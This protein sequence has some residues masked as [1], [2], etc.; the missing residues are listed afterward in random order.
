MPNCQGE[1]KIKKLNKRVCDLEATVLC[2]Q[3]R[4]ER[5]TGRDFDNP[6]FFFFSTVCLFF[7]HNSEDPKIF[8][9]P[10]LS[11]GL[12]KKLRERKREGGSLLLRQS[13]LVLLLLVVVDDVFY[14]VRIPFRTAPV[15]VD[16]RFRSPA[17]AF[18]LHRVTKCIRRPGTAS[19]RDRGLR[20]S[21][22]HPF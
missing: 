16:A 7:V 22:A 9:F 18:P 5:G 10:P 20:R 12:E 4:E 11:L 21:T 13:L 8:V 17:I 1:K 2:L 6:L 3:C 14:N 15:Y 19:P